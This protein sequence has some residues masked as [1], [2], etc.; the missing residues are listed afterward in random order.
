[1]KIVILERG[2]FGHDIPLDGLQKLGDVTVYEN[3][4]QNEV[5]ALTKDADIILVNKLLM[6]ESSLKNATNLKLICEI[7]TGYNN[8]DLDYC[9]SRGITVTNVRNYSTPS[10][11][12]HTFALLLSVY[13]RLSYYDQFV[14]DGTY[15]KTA[16]FSHIGKGFH[17]LAGKTYGI[18][19]LG[20]IGRKVAQIASAFDCNV[21]YYS[22][23]DQTYDVPY[24]KVDFDTLLT[25]SDILSIHCPLTD[26]THHLL[27]Y[28]CFQKMKRDSVVI[29]VG[30]GPI[31]C[32]N[33]LA[34][35]LNEGLIAGAGLDVFEKEPIDADNP[36]LQV[37]NNH[38]LVMVPHIG[39]GSVEART[40]LIKDVEESIIAFQNKTPRSVVI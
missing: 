30:R 38:N 25:Q 22:A 18:I 23:S 39:W 20:N 8:I 16:S 26:K 1:M 21:I 24:Q 3:A 4:N 13:E 37:Q 31:I 12:Q 14:K 36:L 6:N 40:R 28:N 32:E 5:P 10:V 17:E 7:A 2:S 9:K 15:S 33:D 35:A 19:G 29:N 11:A 34:K 27:T